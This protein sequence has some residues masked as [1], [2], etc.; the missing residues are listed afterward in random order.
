M[1]PVRIL[2]F[3]VRIWTGRGDFLTVS[4]SAAKSRL[5]GR[6]SGRVRKRTRR[7]QIEEV[8]EVGNPNQ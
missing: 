8:D 6:G 4:P 7:I 2:R 1:L 5:A 3:P